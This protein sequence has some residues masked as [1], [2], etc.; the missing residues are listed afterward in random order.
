MSVFVS[1]FLIQKQ[2]QNRPW[3][4]PMR[5]TKQKNLDYPNTNS[6]Q[7]LIPQGSVA[8]SSIFLF[9][10]AIASQ[11]LKFELNFVFLFTAKAVVIILKAV[12]WVEYC[13]FI[14]LNLSKMETIPE[15]FVQVF[16]AQDVGQDGLGRQDWCDCIFDRRRN[17][18]N[19]LRGWLDFRN[20]LLQQVVKSCPLDLVP[21][22]I[23]EK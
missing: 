16:C 7:T 17:K 3:F 2:I 8:I 1:V 13:F 6:K 10:L 5:K 18:L 14:H 15:Y 20:C 21:S 22:L 19:H 11:S 4:P 9:P 23:F 12:V